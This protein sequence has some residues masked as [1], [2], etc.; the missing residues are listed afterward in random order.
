MPSIVEM[1][2]S[3]MVK[4]TISSM[5]YPQNDLCFYYYNVYNCFKV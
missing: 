4:A 3:L 2:S 5:A 1:R